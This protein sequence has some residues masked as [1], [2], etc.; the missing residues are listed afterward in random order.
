MEAFY[1]RIHGGWDKVG[2]VFREVL[3]KGC[4]GGFISCGLFPRRIRERVQTSEK[5]TPEK[6]SDGG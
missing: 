3:S 4:L 5:I 1:L 2:S 6:D